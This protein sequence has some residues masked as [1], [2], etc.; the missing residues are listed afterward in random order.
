M[1]KQQ[2]MTSMAAAKA[3]LKSN[4]EGEPAK[5]LETRH[6]FLDTQ[7][8]RSLRHNPAN[9]A[10]TLL[11]EK[12]EAHRVVLH[13]TD[14]TLMEVKRQIRESVIA[15]S[16]ELGSLE[17]DLARWRKA[18]P[19]KGPSAPI[20]MDV[21]GLAEEMFEQFQLFLLS[22]CRAVTHAALSIP[23]GD[24]FHRY[25]RRDPPFHGEDSKEFP[26]A[27]VLE[28]LSRWCETKCERL[29][30]VTKDGAMLKAAN[31]HPSMLTMP[32][33][34]QV[35]TRASADLD[36]DGHA[37]NLAE[38]TINGQDFDG[39][40]KAAMQDQI[41]SVG[42]IYAGE[43]AD[44]EAYQSEL[45]SIE[46]IDRWT[47]VGLSGGRITLIVNA[48]VRVIVEVQY[49][50][51]EDAIYDR[52]DGVWFGAESGSTEVEEEVQLEV[53][54]DLDS[55]RGAVLEARILTPEVTIYGPSEYDF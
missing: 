5:P 22:D 26:D 7:V 8:Y 54:V 9:R 18:S 55:A 53:L 50:D 38:A 15:R 31:E 4:V 2:A 47:V 10:L 41:S 52:E 27:F 28:V 34:H 42:F 39:S 17:Q 36:I 13:T 35:L 33:L 37:K 21:D 51:R 16:R 40:F 14:I 24:V 12:I 30:V 11:R 20:T 45:L 1:S 25:F 23:A 49:E 48:V 29:Y 32:D 3:P 6:I 19:D 43:L 44:G 46:Q